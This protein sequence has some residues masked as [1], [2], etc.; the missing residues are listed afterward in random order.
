MS[1]NFILEDKI[2]KKFC[3]KL[4]DFFNN[5]IDRHEEDLNCDGKKS[6]EIV[7]TNK[8]EIYNEYVDKHLDICLKNYLN[9][10]EHSNNVNYFN[11]STGIKIQY[12]KPNEGF[13]N[14]HFENDGHHPDS[15]RHLVFMTYLND[16]EDGGTEFLY[17]NVTTK[18]I[19][20]NNIIWP[21]IWTHTH[22][23]QISTKKV[24]YIITGW[25]GF[26]E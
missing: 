1:E 21:A 10:Y 11:V 16:V 15:K 12:Y 3:D 4:I 8:D 14:W 22:R 20:G 2:S 23:G 26:N 17:Q 9:K 24:K 13:Y 5:N 18:A 19:K 6:K 25:F 7:L